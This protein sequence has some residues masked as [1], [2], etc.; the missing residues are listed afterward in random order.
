MNTDKPKDYI[1][2]TAVKDLSFQ[3]IF[4]MGVQRSGTSILYKMLQKTGYFTV[5]TA[6]H[7]IYFDELLFNYN[8]EKENETKNKLSRLLAK[9]EQQNRGIDELSVT[10]EFPEEYGFLL[11]RKTNH[12]YIDSSSLQFFTLL[13]KKVQYLSKNNNPIL[14]KNPF[15]FA[16]FIY[17]KKQFPQAKFVFIHRNPIHTLSSQLK[18][19]KTLF[20]KKSIYMSLLSP[21]YNHV[22][23]HGLLRK[24]YQL[25]SSPKNP[26]RVHQLITTFSHKAQ[27]YMNNIE[28]LTELKDYVSIRYEDLCS[29]PQH[30]METILNFLG[31]NRRDTI[32]FSTFI[33][34]RNLPVHKQIQ[35]RKQ[36]LRKNIQPYLSYLQYSLPHAD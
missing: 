10:P 28:Q 23:Q 1:Y 20:G 36:K 15:D 32:D 31:K 24:Y 6:Y 22:F 5:T 27:Y 11:S 35:K 8:N 18:A 34:P 16:N 21:W 19:M 33:K 29:H 25:V 12:Q 26:L 14:L 4:I 3:P 7:I 9:G 17:I 2:R 30:T 13:C